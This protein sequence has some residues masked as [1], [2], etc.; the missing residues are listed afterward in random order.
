MLKPLEIA[1]TL[2]S[3]NEHVSMSNVLLVLKGIVQNLDKPVEVETT[4]ISDED[5][6]DL[7]R[8]IGELP[9]LRDYRNTVKKEIEE[10][11]NLNNLDLKSVLVVTTVDP[12]YKSMNFLS[13]EQKEFVKQTIIDII[14][15]YSDDT[16]IKIENSLEQ[17]SNK[18]TKT[19]RFR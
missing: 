13:S 4:G 18:K 7:N 10:R 6:E 14:A 8:I 15:S 3:Y 5:D 17:P 16:V 9:A 12:R 2:F 11:W 19:P 1:T